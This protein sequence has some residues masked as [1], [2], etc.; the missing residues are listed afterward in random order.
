[1]SKSPLTLVAALLTFA[2]TGPAWLQAQQSEIPPNPPEA[3]ARSG[4][5]QTERIVEHRPAWYSVKRVL[6]PITWLYEGVR[7]VLGLA[8]KAGANG[9]GGKDDSVP[10]SGVRLRVISLGPG[11]GFGPEVRPFHHDVLGSKLKVDIPLTITT[12]V[13]ESF[14]FVA[15]YPIVPEGDMDRVTLDFSGVYG[16]RPSENFFGIGNDTGESNQ[17]RFRSVSRSAAVGLGTHL[18]RSL[19]ARVE[20]GYRNV[21]IT[22]PRSF[23]STQDVASPSL[24]GLQGGATMRSLAA[25]LGL[26]TRDRK[27]FAGAGTLQYIEASVNE[28]SGD[29]DFSYWR[30]RYNAQQFIPLSR[31]HRTVIDLRGELETNREKGGSAI[32]FFDLPAIGAPETLAGFAPRRF[33]DK[34]TVNYSVEYR[35]R[36]W[37]YFDWGLFLSQGQVAPQIGDFGLDRFH[38]GYGMRF[39]VRPSGDQSIAL[40]IGR[41]REGWVL[42]LNFSPSF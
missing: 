41:S 30:F 36:I 35:Y 25:S 3:P 26:D 20:A 13:Y 14:G 6:H 29:D 15:G 22:R 16:S 38:T 1:M 17:S 12:N 24:P 18:T 31:D 8:E 23:T 42:Y 5:T 11:S 9:P 2:L 32:P 7:P 40:D 39:L 19:T 28:G 37:R 34:S 21:G 4:E 10:V 27:T 33:T